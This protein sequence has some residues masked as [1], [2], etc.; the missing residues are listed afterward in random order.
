MVSKPAKK[1][2]RMVKVRGVRESRVRARSRRCM[3]QFEGSKIKVK[4]RWK[5]EE[6]I[7]FNLPMFNLK[8][9]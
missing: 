3:G 4:K 6:S 2:E 1:P 7:T 9:D 8:R 5:A